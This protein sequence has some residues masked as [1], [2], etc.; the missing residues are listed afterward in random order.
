[1]PVRKISFAENTPGDQPYNRGGYFHRLNVNKRG[2][3]L[4]LSNPKGIEIFKKLVKMCDIVTEN[5][6][7]RVMKNFGLNYEVLKEI[8]PKIIMVSMSGFGQTGPDCNYTAYVPVMEAAGLGA[9]T[10]YR[11]EELGALEPILPK[12]TTPEWSDWI[13]SKLDKGMPFMSGTGYGDW[14]LGTTG[15]AAVLASLHYCRKTGKGQHI[16]ISGREAIV[17]HVGEVVVDYSMNQRL[18]E[19]MGNRHPSMAPHG[20]YRCKGDDK[21]VAIAVGTEEEWRGFCKAIGDP[22]WTK[23]ERFSIVSNRLNNQDDLD[24]LVEQW[25]SEH[26]H[27]EAME[28]LQKEGVAAGAVIDPK[29]VIYNPQLKER[30]FFRVVDQGP[31]IGKRPQPSQMAAKFSECPT[32][33]LKASPR[34]GEDNEYVMGELLGMSKEELTE[35]EEEQVIGTRALNQP[36]Q[37]MVMP[38]EF[39][40]QAGALKIYS[41]YREQMSEF[42]GEK[43]GPDES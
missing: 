43:I 20:S 13:N 26:E 34:L 17:R 29:E 6:S 32:F 42:F 27:I 8:N 23:E 2:I 15:M 28:I 5:Y 37:E 36:D 18:W 39:G 35:L 25:T 11:P 19:R 31:G 24:K 38:L 22:A 9:I 4:D 10:G 16:D 40:A 14:L 3:T 33:P 12:P 1:M 7:P 30:N 21:W 41:D